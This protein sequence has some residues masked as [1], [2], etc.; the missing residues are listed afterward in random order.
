MKILLSAATSALAISLLAGC[1]GDDDGPTATDPASTPASESKTPVV[2]PTVGTYP[3][4]EA[5]DYTFVLEQICFCPL[6]GPVRVT[7]EDGEVTSA[8]IVKGARGGLKKGE[9]APDYLWLTINDVIAA[10][11][12]TEADDVEVDWPDG[13]DWPNR[14]AVDRFTEAV[15]EEVTYVVRNVEIG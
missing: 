4:L 12:D 3:E 2:E 10:A 11:N 5:S 6:T 9:D 14:V 13:Q 15:D 8:V 7:V 1:S